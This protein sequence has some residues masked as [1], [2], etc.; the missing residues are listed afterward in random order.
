MFSLILSYI[1]GSESE[2]ATF[3]ELQKAIDISRGNLSIQIKTME[4]VEYVSVEKKFHDNKPQTTIHLTEKG[5]L[6]LKNYL[7]G[8]DENIQVLK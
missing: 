3:M 6:A 8:I 1:T 2:S 4:E 7:K 5:R